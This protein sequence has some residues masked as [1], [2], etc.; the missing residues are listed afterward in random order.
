MAQN[1]ILQENSKSFI[2][3]NYQNVLYNI[4]LIANEPSI[5]KTW[6]MVCPALSNIYNT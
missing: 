4:S 6:S 3:T 5:R 2:F 1:S